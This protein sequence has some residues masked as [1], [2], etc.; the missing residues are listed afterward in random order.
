MFIVG[1]L[2]YLLTGLVTG[3]AAW[4]FLKGRVPWFG[5]EAEI[6]L[7]PYIAWL[8][9]FVSRL[10]LTGSKGWGNL[11]VEPAALGLLVPTYC[12]TRVA[13]SSKFPSKRLPLALLCASTALGCFVGLSVP[14]IGSP[15]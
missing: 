15:C 4:H 1:Y 7:L 2:L 13:L 10:L 5:W 8:G 6:L 9:G 12:L 11:S 14:R 3:S